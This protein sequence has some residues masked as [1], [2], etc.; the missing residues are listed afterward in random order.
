VAVRANG[1]EVELGDDQNLHV[2]GTDLVIENPFVGKGLELNLGLLWL[3]VWAEDQHNKQD[4]SRL[5]ALLLNAA[6]ASVGNV[7][8]ILKEGA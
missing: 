1:L 2:V 3:M 7:L 8:S 6:Q 4:P 5:R